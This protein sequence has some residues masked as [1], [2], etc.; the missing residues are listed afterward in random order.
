MFVR[1]QKVCGGFVYALEILVT[2]SW[3][4]RERLTNRFV[5]RFANAWNIHSDAHDERSVW[6]EARRTLWTI[7]PN[8]LMRV[9]LFCS[10][11]MAHKHF[12]NWLFA[13]AAVA[14]FAALVDQQSWMKPCSGQ[15]VEVMRRDKQNRKHHVALGGIACLCFKRLRRQRT[16]RRMMF[17]PLICL[18]AL[19]GSFLQTLLW[20]AWQGRF[21][22]SGITMWV[23]YTTGR[24]EII[25]ISQ[26][27]SWQILSIRL[28][29]ENTHCQVCRWLAMLW[30]LSA[31]L[32]CFGLLL[33]A[34]KMDTWEAPSLYHLLVSCLTHC[35]A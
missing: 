19:Y 30:S 35:W 21:W 4:A 22:L 31:S 6:P 8:S 13:G 33:L 12:E 18:T 34:P 27:E 5:K 24:S 15:F 25:P 14:S 16:L 17:F 20:G 11:H 2:C 1:C 29:T 26:D 7:H 32:E 10:L 9:L 28:P 3:F 23:P